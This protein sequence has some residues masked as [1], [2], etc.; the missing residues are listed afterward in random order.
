MHTRPEQI[1]APQTRPAL[2]RCCA[3]GLTDRGPD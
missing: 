2:G 3:L 1:S